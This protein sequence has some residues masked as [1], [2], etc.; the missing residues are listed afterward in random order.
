LEAILKRST[1]FPGYSWW[2][3][4]FKW[5]TPA[6]VECMG[7]VAALHKKLRRGNHLHEKGVP[8]YQVPLF[9]LFVKNDMFLDRPIVSVRI[10]EC[11]FI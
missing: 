5:W 9:G 10:A 2:R 6:R 1:S 3:K 4:R 11:N 7:W 8:K